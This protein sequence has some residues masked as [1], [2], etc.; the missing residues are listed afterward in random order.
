[1]FGMRQREHGD[2][3]AFGD[4]WLDIARRIWSSDEP[5]DHDGAHFR[6]RGAIGRPAP[7]GGTTP[8]LL[9]AGSS[10]AGRAFAARNCD[11]LFTVIVTLDR[12][13]REL[14]YFRRLAAGHGRTV[15]VL[16]PV[17]VVCRPT[18]E[19][20]EAYHQHYAHDEADWP[21]VDR[22]MAQMGVHAQSFPPEYFATYRQRFAGG[23]GTYPIVGD[24]DDV[25]AE[26]ARIHATGFDGV[27][28]GF[29]NY[30]DELPLFADEVLPRLERLGVWAARAAS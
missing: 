4:E 17:Y 19:E 13:Q 22:L 21:A 2:R 25:A 18:R 8:L 23:G 12:S 15:G 6:L 11:F 10:P 20:A 1:M 28:V 5:F 3:Y 9:N 14:A 27:A 26:L 24:P 16:T 30:A 7:Y 29:V